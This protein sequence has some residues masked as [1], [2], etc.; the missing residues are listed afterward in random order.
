MEYK[1]GQILTAKK[2]FEITKAL[3][4]E[5][6]V[7]PEGTEVIIGADNLVHNIS[8]DMIQPM[9]EDDTVKGYDVEGIAK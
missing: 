6:V 9:G 4:G 1:I 5:K 2:D 3:S 7:I 8:N